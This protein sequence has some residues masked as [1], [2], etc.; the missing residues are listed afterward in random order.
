MSATTPVESH[1]VQT[2]AYGGLVD[3]LG[4]VATAVL[5]IIG[6]TGFDAEGMAGIATIVFGAA[7]LVQGG[8]IVSEYANIIV[9]AAGSSSMERTGGEGLSAMFLVGAA[10]VVLGV[11]ALLGIAS[12]TLTTVAVI[13]FGSALI[14]GSSLVRQLYMLQAQILQTALP[15]STTEMLAGQ[16]A[17]G[18][19]GVQLLAGLATVVLGI[20]AVAG[21]NPTVLT[22]SALLLLGITVLMTGSTLSGL[23]LSF[24]RPK[25]TE[26]RRLGA[27]QA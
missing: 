8:T 19:A 6:L 20:L 14:L 18:T 10:G 22:L 23:V 5:A 9:P 15:R 4:G 26:G 2:A 13:A 25:P 16:M 7:L 1:S 17:A 21:Q 3:A 24:I 27:G 11:L 12:V